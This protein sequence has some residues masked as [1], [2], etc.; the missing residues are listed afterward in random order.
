MKRNATLALAISLVLSGT[1]FAGTS[2]SVPRHG[3][4][5][6]ADSNDNGLLSR[7]EL[8]QRQSA[9][10]THFDLIDSNRDGQLSRQEIGSF[11]RARRLQRRVVMMQKLDDRVATADLDH[12]GLLSESEVAQGDFKRLASHFSTLDVNGDGMLSTHEIRAGAMFARAH[13]HRAREAR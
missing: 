13:Q 6:Q 1:V 9:L 12:N 3:R 11:L 4:F 2:A 10:V 8:E 5:L 7:N